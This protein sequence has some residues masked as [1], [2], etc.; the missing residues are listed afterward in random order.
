MESAHV[1]FDDDG[2]FWLCFEVPT[3]SRR[4]ARGIVRVMSG[5][6]R[7]YCAEIGEY[8]KK[9]SNNANSY[10][11]SLLGKLAY[12]I[13]IP[14]EEVYRSLVQ[15]LGLNYWELAMPKEMYPQFRK[16]WQAK[17]LGWDMRPT[18]TEYS[19]GKIE[20]HA[21]YGSSAF[22]S[23]MMSKFIDLIIQEC[24]MQDIE[25]LP[26]DRLAALVEGWDKPNA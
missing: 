16:D 25:T 7:T 13:G 12:E 10:A 6:K 4:E 21:Y 26:P 19:D 20:V 24:R 14:R 22:D 3:E 8:R 1:K 17:G 2:K 5:K 9:R 23:K 11:W 18:G 15:E